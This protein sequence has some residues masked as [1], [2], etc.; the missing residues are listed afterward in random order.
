MSERNGTVVVQW[1]GWRGGW[2]FWRQ[3]GEGGGGR[4][5]GHVRTGEG[6]GEGPKLCTVRHPTLYPIPPPTHPKKRGGV[7]HCG[8]EFMNYE[9][10]EPATQLNSDGA[11]RRRRKT[12]NLHVVKG[13]EGEESRKLVDAAATAQ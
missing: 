5:S 1:V 7:A 10:E 8:M 3:W 2:V 6:G 12:L 13:G 9:R 11:K 4:R